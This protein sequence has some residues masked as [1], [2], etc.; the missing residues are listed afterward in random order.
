MW[1]MTGVAV[2]GLA[3]LVA[4]GVAS[5]FAGRAFERELGAAARGDV[6]TAIRQDIYRRAGLT[7]TLAQPASPQAP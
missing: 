1:V 2:A 4:W 7:A 6:V 3:A 5:H